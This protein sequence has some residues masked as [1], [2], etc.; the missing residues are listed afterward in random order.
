M[1]YLFYTA[2]KALLSTVLGFPVTERHGLSGSIPVQG[3]INIIKGLEHLSHEDRQ[4][5]FGSFIFFWRKEGSGRLYSH[6]QILDVSEW[7]KD[8]RL[9]SGVPTNGAQLKYM[10]I[11][12]N[13]IIY[14]FT[15]FLGGQTLVQVI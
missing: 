13:T 1:T 14:L 7:R 6:V 4:R 2:S 9:F 3:L 11:H 5:E 10:K 12:L 8:T 15:L